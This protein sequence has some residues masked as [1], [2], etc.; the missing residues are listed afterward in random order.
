MIEALR[1]ENKTLNEVQENAI[2]QT[3]EFNKSIKE[4]KENAIK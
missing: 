1:K 2:K 3:K 4:L